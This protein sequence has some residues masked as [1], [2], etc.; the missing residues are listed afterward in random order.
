MYSTRTAA[1][2]R[3][4]LR[5]LATAAVAFAAVLARG[6]FGPPSPRLVGFPPLLCVRRPP[7]G[8]EGKDAGRGP[9]CNPPVHQVRGEDQ[10]LL[11]PRRARRG[12]ALL[13]P[14]SGTPL[15]P[16]AQP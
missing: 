4:A 9:L 3:V 8:R 13:H 14:E 5:S 2:L 6:V 12:V 10:E 11:A 15:P 1:L 7:G 16:V